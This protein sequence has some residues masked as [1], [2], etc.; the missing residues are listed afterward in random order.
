[1]SPKKKALFICGDLP[2]PV[3]SGG[4]KRELQLLSELSSNYDTELL[5]ITRDIANDEVNLKHIYDL[6]RKATL[7]PANPALDCRLTQ[8][9]QIEN[10]FKRFHT[11]KVNWWLSENIKNFDQVHIERGVIMPPFLLGTRMPIIISEQNIESE[12]VNQVINT[13]N[14]TDSDQTLLNQYY[15]YL[16]KY[17]NLVWNSAARIITITKNDAKVIRSRINDD[18]KVIVLPPKINH[19]KFSTPP[20]KIIGETIN[21]MYLGNFNYYP[22]TYAIKNI[23]HEIIPLLKENGVNFRFRIIGNG[24]NNLRSEICDENITITDFKEDVDDYWEWAH[25]LVAPIF[26]GSGLKIKVQEALENR[27]PVITT[28]SGAS[29]FEHYLNKYVY[30]CKN[31]LEFTTL[32][33]GFIN[34]PESYFS[35]TKNLTNENLKWDVP[36]VDY[37]PPD[38]FSSNL[39]K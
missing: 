24:A 39:Q 32:I 15:E 38:M 6:T 34:N 36:E 37:L 13:E 17:E 22:N 7:L 23:L 21:L 19:S 4:R 28:D 10:L 26:Y 9:A 12:I 31:S 29:G 1:M 3:V 14:L 8:D 2:Y 25:L 33:G 5:C 16:R 20:K 18:S 35:M 30:I 11:K 27:T